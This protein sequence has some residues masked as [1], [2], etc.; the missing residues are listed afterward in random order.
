MFS[1]FII[2]AVLVGPLPGQV[3]FIDNF[4]RKD[5]GKVLN[6]IDILDFEEKSFLGTFNLFLPRFLDKKNLEVIRKIMV[7]LNS[8]YFFGLKF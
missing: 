2:S 8:K 5:E 7:M 6:F 3:L 1:K 4:K